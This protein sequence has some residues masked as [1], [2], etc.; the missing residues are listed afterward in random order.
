MSLKSTPIFDL[1]R[2]DYDVYADASRIGTWS[3]KPACPKCKTP[4]RKRI[5]PLVIEWNEGSD[6]MADVTFTGGLED[7]VVTGRVRTFIKQHRLSGVQF[8]AVSM[9]QDRW[10]KKSGA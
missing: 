5:P 1:T 6:V 2:L 4:R 8:G 3:S 9:I 7:I 10:L